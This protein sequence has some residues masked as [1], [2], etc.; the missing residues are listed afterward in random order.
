MSSGRPLRFVAVGDIGI[1][2]R[3]AAMAT[4]DPDALLRDSSPLFA[5][6]DQVFGNLEIPFAPPGASIDLPATGAAPANSAQLLHR[7]G[8][9]VLSLANNHIMDAGADG[10]AWT[11]SSLR[12]A[13]VR[14]VGAGLNESE[15]FEPLRLDTNPPLGV[16]AYSMACKANARGRRAGSA[17]YRLDVARTELATLRAEG[18]RVIVSLHLGRMYLRR[19]APGH[20][21]AVA[22][23]LDQ[24]ADLVLC[25]HAHVPAGLMRRAGG[26]GAAG[27][28]DF[29]FDAYRGEIRTMIGRRSRKVGVLL[30]ADFSSA[31]LG[32]VSRRALELPDHGGPRPHPRESRILQGWKHWDR[33]LQWPEPVY[34]AVY[35]GLE[36]PRLLAYV[37]HAALIHLGRN[38]WK[39]AHSYTFG[40]LANRLTRGRSSD[41]PAD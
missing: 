32:T 25:H 27:L 34:R 6:A 38:N 12:E 30:S 35:Y 21:R 1:H 40:L 2:G 39:K 16:L 33:E 37:G 13:G 15:A 23:L 26:A 10:L 4:A 11:L 3:H 8:F 17:R 7:W 24:G 18:R 9:T 29:L 41:R 14:T 36:Y 5:G 20:R 28:G 22:Q 31:G 19:P